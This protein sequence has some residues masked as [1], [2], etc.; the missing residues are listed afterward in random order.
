MAS[1][2]VLDSLVQEYLASEYHDIAAFLAARDLELELIQAVLA[3]APNEELRM[4]L[5]GAV[6]ELATARSVLR[7]DT[8]GFEPCLAASR[9]RNK[10]ESDIRAIITEAGLADDDWR[11]LVPDDIRTPKE[12]VSCKLLLSVKETLRCL[13]KCKKPLMDLG[14]GLREAMRCRRGGPSSWNQQRP[15]VTTV[16]FRAA[17]SL[18]EASQQESTFLSDDLDVEF[19]RRAYRALSEDSEVGWLAAVGRDKG[20]GVDGSGTGRGS[21]GNLRAADGRD[22]LE[23]SDDHP[24]QGRVSDGVL[25][26]NDGRRGS[27]Q[28]GSSIWRSRGKRPFSENFEDEFDDDMERQGDGYHFMDDQ[29]Q[30]DNDHNFDDPQKNVPDFPDDDDD[31][32]LPLSPPLPPGSAECCDGRYGTQRKSWI[33]RNIISVLLLSIVVAILS[34]FYPY[35]PYWDEMKCPRAGTVVAVYELDSRNAIPAEFGGV[36]YTFAK[37]PK[38]ISTFTQEV[39]DAQVTLEALLRDTVRA[40][41]EKISKD[42][43]LVDARMLELQLLLRKLQVDVES[44]LTDLQAEKSLGLVGSTSDE[45]TQAALQLQKHRDALLQAKADAKISW[46]FSQLCRLR[47]HKTIEA[48]DIKVGDLKE[49]GSGEHVGA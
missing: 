2:S 24:G 16:D 15:Y 38:Q 44:A 43:E 30:D 31:F 33:Q 46:L 40:A 7:A 27:E 9:N 42:R 4:T 6:V 18:F 34:I 45:I 19:G 39:E 28:G 48:R 37:D 26:A 22:G 17:R 29:V 3:E 20:K 8:P 49:L 10:H 35:I 14:D 25:R 41:D 1:A 32:A 36:A 12:L 5:V 13:V 21:D 47:L 23:E 11:S